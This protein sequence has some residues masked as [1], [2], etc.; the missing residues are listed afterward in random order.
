MNPKNQKGILP[1]DFIGASNNTFPM[2]RCPICKQSGLIDDDQF[3]GQV[4][5]Q[6]ENNCTYHETKDWSQNES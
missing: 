4:S 5:I 3:H 1:K 2:F 6:C